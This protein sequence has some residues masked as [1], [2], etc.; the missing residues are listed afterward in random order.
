MIIAIVKINYYYYIGSDIND[1]SDESDLM[2]MAIG[3]LMV[4]AEWSDCKC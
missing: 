4:K 1:E 2:V 3:T